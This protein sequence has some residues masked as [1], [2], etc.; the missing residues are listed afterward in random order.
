MGFHKL[1]TA[2]DTTLVKTFYKVKSDPTIDLIKN[3]NNVAAK[4]NLN[5]AQLVCGISFNK[6]I[7]DLTDI[8]T[9]LGFKSYKIMT[10]RRNELFT[11]DPYQQLSIDNILDIYSARLE[12]KEILNTI[13][14]LIL[15]RLSYIE[16]KMEKSDDPS[17]TI[18]YRMEVHSIYTSGIANKSFSELR[19]NKKISKYRLL[20]SEL[21]EMIHAEIF[22]PSNLFFM[23]AIMPNEKKALIENNHI[24]E[25]M[26]KNRMQNK[27]ISTEERELLEN[28][29]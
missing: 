13:R 2:T 29:L 25:E 4:L 7:R 18:S 11:T 22:P 3:I 10:Y 8:I 12:D 15:P 24:S 14:E 26:I 1:L 19:I 21:E 5:H 9:V 23:D 17:L 20:A 16:G 6:N 27:K 28:L